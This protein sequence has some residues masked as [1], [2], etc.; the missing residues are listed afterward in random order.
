MNL[1]ERLRS[2]KPKVERVLVDGD[3]YL[4]SSKSKLER[5]RLFARSKK[6][7]GSINSDMLESLMLEACVTTED[8]T[9]APVQD[10]DMAPSYV[11]GPLI[12]AI[13]SV[14]GMDKDDLGRDPKDLDS[15]ES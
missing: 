13:M 6:K 7:D 15:T 5:G 2:K 4:V 10:W 12:N 3:I 9:N 14:N 11:T 1:S 8:G